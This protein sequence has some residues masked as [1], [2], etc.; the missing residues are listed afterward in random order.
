MGEMDLSHYVGP[1]ARHILIY[2]GGQ[3][4]FLSSPKLHPQPAGA[5]EAQGLF[6]SPSTNIS[7]VSTTCLLPGLA[8]SSL[9]E[10]HV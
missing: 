10:S 4:L 6:P 5:T 1:P 2:C 7:G 9:E 3:I 8:A